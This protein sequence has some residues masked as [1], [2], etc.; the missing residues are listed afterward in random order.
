[1]SSSSPIVQGIAN[2]IQKSD[3]RRVLDGGKA[4]Q[5]LFKNIEEFLSQS[6]ESDISS[7]D[8]QEI[9]GRIEGNT[10][11]VEEEFKAPLA[12]FISRLERCWVS[13]LVLV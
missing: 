11:K 10:I 8:V 6:K 3:L 1:M 13:C 12:K 2:L 4:K 7:N 5:E 9:L